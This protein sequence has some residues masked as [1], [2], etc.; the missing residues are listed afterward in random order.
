MQTLGILNLLVNRSKTHCVLIWAHLREN[1]EL[2][3]CRG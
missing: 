3:L 1:K 2:D